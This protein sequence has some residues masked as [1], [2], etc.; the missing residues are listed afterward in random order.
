VG[1]I[2]PTAFLNCRYSVMKSAMT[3]VLSY[4]SIRMRRQGHVTGRM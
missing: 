1:R 3:S 4:M 2:E